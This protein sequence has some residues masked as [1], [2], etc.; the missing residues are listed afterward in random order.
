MERARGAVRSV[1]DAPALRSQNGHD[2]KVTFLVICRLAVRKV[3]DKWNDALGQRSECQPAR[4]PVASGLRRA[5]YSQL[6]IG[7]AAGIE[8]ATSSLGSWLCRVVP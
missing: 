5:A 7:G 8:P 2:P 1:A 3:R 6:A 4:M